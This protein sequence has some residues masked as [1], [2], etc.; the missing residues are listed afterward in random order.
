MAEFI[1]IVITLIIVN[2]SLILSKKWKKLNKWG[3]LLRV[4]SIA[5]SIIISYNQFNSL[6]KA[7]LIEKVQAKFGNIKDLNGATIPRLCGGKCVGGGWPLSGAALFTIANTGPL[8]RVYIKNAR[9][10]V[11]III[12]DKS[13]NP[14]AVIDENEWTVFSN[15][16]EYNNNETGFEIVTK[17]DRKVYFQIYLERGIAHILGIVT[18]KD[19]IGVK[20]MQQEPNGEIHLLDKDHDYES[21]LVTMILPTTDENKAKKAYEAVG[22]PI[23]K[24][25]RERYLG[26]R[27]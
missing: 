17:G 19:G 23:F 25:P 20:F 21:F 3:R 16:Y 2:L 14:I 5:G 4:V 11:D 27:K 7:K 12:R 9:L 26:V 6:M 10:F 13:L 15:D 8:F 18:N 1:G 22:D 24:Y